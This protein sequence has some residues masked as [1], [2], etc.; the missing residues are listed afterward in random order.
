MLLIFRQSSFCEECFNI[1]QCDVEGHCDD[2]IRACLDLELDILE[3]LK[4]MLGFIEVLSL[5][6]LRIQGD[7]KGDRRD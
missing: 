1:M 4:V 3:M 7:P 6:L 2:P 5:V